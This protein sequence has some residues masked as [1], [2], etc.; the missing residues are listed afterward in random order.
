LADASFAEAL[1]LL[2]R[3]AV[4]VE[5]YA[6]AI[7]VIDGMVPL[8]YRSVPGFARTPFEAP[9]TTEVD[10]SVPPRLP[11]SHRPI[12][13]LL[14]DARLVPFESPGYRGQPGAQAFQDAEHGTQR[15]AP[16]FVEF[17][18]PLLGKGEKTLVEV[19]P[20][21]RAE[22][23]RYLDLLAFEPIVLQARDVPALTIDATSRL[24]VP[25]P[26]IYVAQ[27]ILARSSGRLTKA[28]KAA[29]DL[30]YVFDVAVLSRPALSS[31]RDIVV[32]A[33]GT[34]KAWRAWLARAGRQ[35]KVLFET[36][37][38]EGPVEAA[39][40]L[41]DLMGARAPSEGDVQRV[42]TRFAEQVFTGAV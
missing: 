2:G 4:A 16:T 34:H 27:K 22:A 25:Q 9:G 42:V 26:A 1:R 40:I 13:D 39:R 6:S 15:K 7:L 3:V 5:P 10:M 19:Q 29:K 21:F 28:H 8:L 24:Q 17:L 35:L 23:L 36:P 18:A 11:V 31:Q 41:R 37:T 14:T 30:A 12:L 38:S 33:A 20:G 32:R